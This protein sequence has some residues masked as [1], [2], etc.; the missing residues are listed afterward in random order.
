[1]AEK[2]IR[3]TKFLNFY[4]SPRGRILRVA[5]GLALVGAAI[6]YKGVRRAGMTLFGIA[7]LFGG[8]FD[9]SIIAPL[10]GGKFDG[11]SLR[12]SLEGMA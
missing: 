2:Q 3:G 11:K 12:Q 6:K 5:A 10:L 7:P 4:S 9:K 1:M 8:T